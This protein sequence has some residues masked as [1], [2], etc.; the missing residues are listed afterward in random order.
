MVLEPLLAL[1]YML[2]PHRTHS[3]LPR[4]EPASLKTGNR[5]YFGGGVALSQIERVEGC[6]ASPACKTSRKEGFACKQSTLGTQR[7]LRNE[8]V[9]CIPTLLCGMAQFLHS[10]LAPGSQRLP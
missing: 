1:Q 8:Q 10:I 2:L 3:E 7:S 6:L 5:I 9:L 4:C